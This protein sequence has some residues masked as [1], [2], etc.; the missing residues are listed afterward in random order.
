MSATY[1]SNM[2]A[3]MPQ[4]R[5]GLVGN[6]DGEVYSHGWE[7]ITGIRLFSHGPRHMLRQLDLRT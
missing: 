4:R 3:R 2:A 6:R 5:V 7:T 1:A